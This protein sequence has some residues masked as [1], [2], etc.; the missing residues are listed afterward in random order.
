M[1]SNIPPLESWNIIDEDVCN[2]VKELFSKGKLLRELNATLITLVPKSAFIRERQITDNILLTKELLK[3]YDCVKGPKRCSMKIDIQKAYDTMNWKFL[4]KPLR[5]FGFHSTMVHWIMTCVTSPS[6]TICLNGERHGFF[7]GGRGLRQ[8]DPLSPYLFT[9]VMEVFNLILHQEIASNGRFKY[10]NGCKDLKITHLCFADDLLVLCHGDINSV[11]TIKN[12]LEIFS[13][14][15][16]LYPN[17]GKSTIFCGSMDK[18]TINDVLQILPFKKGKLPIRYLGV[19]LVSK[20]IGVQDCKD[21][22]D[23]VKNRIQDWKNKSLSYAGRTQLIASVL[24]SIQV[25]WASVFKLPKMVINDIEN[26]FKGFLW[27][28]GEFQ[29]GKAKVVWKEVCQAKMNEVKWISTVKLRGRS[30]WEVEKQNNDSWI[31]KSLLDLRN[32]IRENM[33]YNIGDGRKA[34]V[35]H[36]R[37]SDKPSLDTILSRRDIY[38]A[39]FANNDIVYRINNDVEDK[40]VWRTSNGNLKASSYLQKKNETSGSSNTETKELKGCLD[41]INPNCFAST[42]MIVSLS[43]KA[44]DLQALIVEPLNRGKWGYILLDDALSFSIPF[45]CGCGLNDWGLE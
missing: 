1:S 24:S 30:V 16:G 33:I 3:G 45:Y 31:W 29:R 10:H 7:K 14:V 35:W 17:L 37:W 15:S 43:W 13:A 12:A 9:I 25:Y 4:E 44:S 42:R 19:P 40:L 11:N 36:D 32:V 22:I 20:K 34:S 26:L 18:V 21:L 27:N 8:R 38:S 23:K 6:Y 5:L 39:G 2:A 28:S 41:S